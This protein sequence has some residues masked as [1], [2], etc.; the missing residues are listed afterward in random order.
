MPPASS[1]QLTI[2]DLQVTA[3]ARGGRGLSQAYVIVLS[4]L[5]C[6][7]AQ[8]HRWESKAVKTSGAVRGA[9]SAIPGSAGACRMLSSVSTPIRSLRRHSTRSCAWVAGNG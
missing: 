2:K 5:E 6:E 1:K 9:L 3:K 8:G 4:R 7:C